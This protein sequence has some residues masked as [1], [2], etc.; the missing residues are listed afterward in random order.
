[1]ALSTPR[2]IGRDLTVT[3]DGAKT[4]WDTFSLT[5][6]FNNEGATAA[7]STLD[8]IVNT[9]KILSGSCSGF[10]GS[11]NNGGTLPAI[12][13]AI[14]DLAVA[15][16][17]DTVLPSLTAFTNIKVTNVKYDFKAGPATFSFDFRSGV[18]N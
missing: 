16:G 7:D 13:D 8:E 2:I 5:F 6:E 9:T 10:L 18:L 4:I 17:S 1:M 3:A 15:V 11:V 12:G 14:S